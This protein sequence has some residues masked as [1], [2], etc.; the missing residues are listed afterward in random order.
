MILDLLLCWN[1]A[2][3]RPPLPEDEVVR[4]VESITRLH[5]RCEE[6]QRKDDSAP[7]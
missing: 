6:E 7:C 2:R 4:T 1:A 3:C 5:L